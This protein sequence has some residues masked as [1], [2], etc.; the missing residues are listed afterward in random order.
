MGLGVWA[1]PAVKSHQAV[2]WG[3]RWA[4]QGGLDQVGPCQSQPICDSRTAIPNLLP[5]PG[6]PRSRAVTSLRCPHAW[7]CD[8]AAAPLQDTCQHPTSP[9]W[10]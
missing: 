5:S 7:G 10:P 6:G 8:L 1:A 9:V 3:C 4:E 2:V